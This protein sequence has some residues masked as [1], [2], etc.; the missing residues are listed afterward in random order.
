MRPTAG[1]LIACR[2]ATQRLAAANLGARPG[3]VD[4]A[5]ITAS[6]NAHLHATAT[7]VVEPIGCRL[8]DAEHPCLPEALDSARV[9]GA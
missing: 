4:V 5:V 7:A 6:T 8:S 2:S 9:A 3:A 1:A